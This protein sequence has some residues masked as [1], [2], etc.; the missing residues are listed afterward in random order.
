MDSIHKSL[1]EIVGEDHVSSQPEELY[2]YSY[3]L[4]TTEPHRPDY[5][6]APRTTE[7]VQQVVKL[8]NMEKI[9]V[10]PLGGGLSLAGLAVPLRGGIALDLKRMDTIIEVNEKARHV[11]I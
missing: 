3:D 6:V 8:A 1:A 10:V 4:G 5:V 11:V 2:I 7:E 9:T